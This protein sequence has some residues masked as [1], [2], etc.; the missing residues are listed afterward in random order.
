[1]KLWKKKKGDVRVASASTKMEKITSVI[2]C[3][4]VVLMIALGTK[5][6]VNGQLLQAF[7]FWIVA[8]AALKM[9]FSMIKSHAEFVAFKNTMIQIQLLESV[10][11]L[12]KELKELK[13]NKND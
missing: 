8:T 5:A 2:T 1:M 13:G 6:Y 7:V 9:E 11:E 3:A 10:N 12:E 4:N